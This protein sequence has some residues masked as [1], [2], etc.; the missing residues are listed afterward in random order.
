[1]TFNFSGTQATFG[2]NQETHMPKSS[3][4]PVERPDL[5]SQKKAQVYTLE[6]FLLGG[7]IADKFVK[8]NPVISRTIKIRGDQSLEHLHGAIFDAYGRWDDH[9]YE[10]RFGKGPSDPNARRYVLPSAFERG[11]KAPPAGRVDRATL[12]SLGLEVGRSFGYWFDFGDDWLHQIDVVGIDDKVPR[13]KLPKVTNR[14][15]KNP[16]QYPDDDD[17]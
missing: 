8:K 14:V 10:F 13:G 3:N 12:D 7:P 16:P 1:M 17:E 11:G 6:V 15:G 4:S 9:M 5:T 2:K